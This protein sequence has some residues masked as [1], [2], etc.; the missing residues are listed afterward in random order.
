MGCLL[1]QEAWAARE[2]EV[3]REAEVKREAGAAREVE[4]A[5]TDIPEA[6]KMV[7]GVAGVGAGVACLEQDG[8]AARSTAMCVEDEAE[9]WLLRASGQGSLDARIA[10]ARLYL[11]RRDGMRVV[12][13][14][15]G[16]LRSVRLTSSKTSARNLVEMAGALGA[17]PA[18]FV[19][20]MLGLSL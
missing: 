15:A 1:L 10:L 7:E 9:T 6:S 18:A 13:L 4:V 11:S 3:A 12:M 14:V 17:V 5:H 2:T 16:W 19:F 8:L 20:V